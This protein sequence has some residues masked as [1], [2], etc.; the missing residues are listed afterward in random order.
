MPI[1]LGK[2]AKGDFNA[3]HYTAEEGEDIQQMKKLTYFPDPKHKNQYNTKTL[4]RNFKKYFE[5]TDFDGLRKLGIEREELR[6]K[7][8]YKHSHKFRDELLKYSRHSRLT[9]TSQFIAGK[10]QRAGKQKKRDLLWEIIVKG[11]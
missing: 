8:K 10:V 3:P 7:V 6:L 9:T 2:L 4:G 1:F 5:K 11:D